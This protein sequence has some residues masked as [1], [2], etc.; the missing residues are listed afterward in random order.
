[1]K[2]YAVY[3]TPPPGLF[4]DF[5]ASWLGW[6]AAHGLAPARPKVDGLPGDL[7]ILTE[8]ARKYG[9]HG[10]IKAPFR[11]H[12]GCT[13]GVLQVACEKLAKT[14]APVQL[15]GLSLAGLDRFLALVPT[16]ET[17]SLSALATAVVQGLDVFRAP[18]TEPEIAKRRP[19][20]LTPRQRDYL[21][22]YGYPYVLEEFQFH[23]TLTGALSA[24]DLAK[25]K[26]A[27][28]PHLMPLLP[29]PFII[30]DLCLCGEG[31][32]GMF[33]VLHRYALTG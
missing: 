4:A 28:T 2:R 6:D 8:A 12:G 27:L 11:L 10:T 1:M 31:D 26:A 14:L 16:G 22:T 5:T 19:D 23:L 20:R 24:P 32:D 18:L 33:R 7:E 17:A 13:G 21:S 15:D 9:F 29:K 30:N 3:Y 25:T